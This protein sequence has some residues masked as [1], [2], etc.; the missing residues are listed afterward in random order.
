MTDVR[1]AAEGHRRAGE[2]REEASGR[3]EPHRIFPG[4]HSQNRFISE[5]V[6]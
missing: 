3:V 1:L 5:H 6:N 4:A 2:P